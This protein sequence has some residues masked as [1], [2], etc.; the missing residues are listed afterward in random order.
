[1]SDELPRIATRGCL[2]L[3]SAVEEME[4]EVSGGLTTVAFVAAA[5]AEPNYLSVRAAWR[6]SG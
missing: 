4:E 3:C 1:M 6:M 5:A 2:A